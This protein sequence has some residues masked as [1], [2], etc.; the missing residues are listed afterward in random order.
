M[1]KPN[2]IRD[3]HQVSVL[4]LLR[5]H[6]SSSRAWLA[7]ELGLT[8]STLSS[9]VG[10]LVAEGYVVESGRPIVRHGT[11]RPGVGLELNPDGAYFLGAEIGYG[12]LRVV[13]MNLAAHVVGHAETGFASD[14]APSNVLD[15]LGALLWELRAEHDADPSRVKGIGVAVPGTTAAGRIVLAPSLGWRDVEVLTPLQEAHGCPVLVENNAN[16]AALAEVYLEE[17]ARDTN[18]VFV[19]L[20]RGIGS[21]V[22]INGEIYRGSFGAAGE[23]GNMRL[24]ADGPVDSKGNRGTFEAFASIDGLLRCHAEEGGTATDLEG[25]MLELEGGAPAAE[26]SLAA[27]NRWLGQAVLMLVNVL[28]PDK[29]VLG[30]AMAP[31]VPAVLPKL[32][33]LVRHEQLPGSDRVELAVS[34]LGQDANA[35]GGAMLVY[36]AM[37]SLPAVAVPG[38]VMSV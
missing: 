36:H 29:I 23:I 11:G 6:G 35:K 32:D 33:A 7:Q 14:D 8:R 21:G 15:R 31:L 26:A 4:N 1:A 28:N 13:L 18:L 16:G 5:R 19:H 37:F 2:L 12:T 9:L 22:I 25:L 30:G 34:A 3:I 24:A 27:W 38:R 20:G 17:E 10:Q